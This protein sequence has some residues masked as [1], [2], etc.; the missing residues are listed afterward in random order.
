ME[1]WPEEI[2]SFMDIYGADLKLKYISKAEISIGL[3]KREF[4]LI[5]KVFLMK[6]II[7]RQEMK[8]KLRIIIIINGLIILRFPSLAV[9][10]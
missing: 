1:Y 8:R 7:K 6:Q 10:K 5:D 3:I 4:L 9:K 2:G